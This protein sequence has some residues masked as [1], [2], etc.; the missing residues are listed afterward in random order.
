ML[1]CRIRCFFTVFEAILKRFQRVSAGG[2][3]QL[4]KTQG[5]LAQNLTITLRRPKY[6]QGMDVAASNHDQ[7]KRE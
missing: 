4:E 2:G 7:L 5:W 3:V 1:S 6:S